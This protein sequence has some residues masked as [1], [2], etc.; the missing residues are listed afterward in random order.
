MTTKVKGRT[1]F[2]I[3]S[4][5][6]LLS[7][8]FELVGISSPVPLFGASRGGFAAAVYHL[9][10]T[11]TYLAL[12]IGLWKARRWCYRLVFMA[13]LLVTL[14]KLQYILYPETMV[15]HFMLH[16]GRYRQLLQAIDTQPLVQAL[17]LVALLFAACWWAFAGYT[18]FRRD[19]FQASNPS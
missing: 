17:M 13:T 5:L 4:V 19:Y 16:S 15:A 3:A 11:T 9:L 12:G 6:F 14:D 8:V 2:R 1:N 18:Y 10:F 7:A